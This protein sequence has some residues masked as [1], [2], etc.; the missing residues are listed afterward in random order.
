MS[1][2]VADLGSK[3]WKDFSRLG[4]QVSQLNDNCQVAMSAFRRPPSFWS[5]RDR[6]G[7]GVLFHKNVVY[8]NR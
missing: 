7:L 3:P 4:D 8:L 1:A 6:R 2:Q 5:A